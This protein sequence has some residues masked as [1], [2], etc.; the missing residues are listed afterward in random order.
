[1]RF[2]YMEKLLHATNKLNSIMKAIQRKIINDSLELCIK[3]PE[4]ET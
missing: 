4:K 2:N 3:P 1:M